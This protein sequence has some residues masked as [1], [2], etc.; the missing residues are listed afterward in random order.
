MKQLITVLLLFGAITIATSQ[1][2][3]L[4][5]NQEYSRTLQTS[6][7]SNTLHFH[8]SVRA[9]YI[10]DIDAVGINYDS[11]RQLLRIEKTFS[12]KWKQKTWDKLLND[13]VATFIKEG[14]AIIINPL[15]NFSYGNELSLTSGQGEE[16]SNSTTWVNTRGLEIKGWIGKT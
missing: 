14:Y 10:P 8:T 15:M 13:D 16:L 1:P 5:L 12:K 4:P 9:Y 11:I 3:Y 7:Y 6:L 2:L